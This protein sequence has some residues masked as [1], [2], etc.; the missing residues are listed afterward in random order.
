M[1]TLTT[2]PVTI[3]ELNEQVQH[4]NEVRYERNAQTAAAWIERAKAIEERNGRLDTRF[5]I[6]KIGRQTVVHVDRSGN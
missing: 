1:V 5:S 6:G 2:E 4:A 3:E